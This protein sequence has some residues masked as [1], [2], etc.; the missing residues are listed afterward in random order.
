MKPIKHNFNDL[1]LT[2]NKTNTVWKFVFTFE[3][4]IVII[5]GIL[6]S[7]YTKIDFT[8]ESF[9]LLVIFSVIYLL[10]K[11]FFLSVNKI[12]NKSPVDELEAKFE[13]GLY[14]KGFSRINIVN[15]TI[16]K[17]LHM[18]NDQ[19]CFLTTEE[20]QEER[21]CNI[22][23]QNLKDGLSEVLGPFMK[24]I[25]IIFDTNNLKFTLGVFIERFGI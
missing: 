8:S 22:C 15:E 23:E 25:S 14:K 9:I 4:L 7:K 5:L 17:S 16:S 10:I 20:H 3:V 21:S 11:L 6:A 13:L 19:T 24:N 18:L 2:I 1:R 12:I